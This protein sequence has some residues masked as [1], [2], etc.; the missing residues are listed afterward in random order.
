M[1]QVAVAIALSV[2]G[3]AA[4]A[5]GPDANGP[6]GFTTDWHGHGNNHQGNNNPGDT[7]VDRH[8]F[9]NATAGKSGKNPTAKSAKRD[10]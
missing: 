4:H 7:A 3:I 8:G 10:N 1:K 2:M 5:G 6:A 9:D